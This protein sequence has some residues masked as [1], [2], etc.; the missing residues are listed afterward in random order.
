[1]KDLNTKKIIRELDAVLRGA[2]K[3]I[4]AMRRAGNFGVERKSR[5]SD[6]VT[7]GDKYAEKVIVA[8][9]TKHFPDHGMRGEEGTDTT[10]TSTTGSSYEWIID[11]IDGTTNY[12]KNNNL[13]GMSVGLYKNGKGV[14]GMIYYPALEKMT[15][16]IVG[17]GA[18]L[19]GKRIRFKKAGG[20]KT[21]EKLKD[22]LVSA[23]I[24]RGK[25]DLFKTLRDQSFNRRI[26]HGREPLA[27]GRAN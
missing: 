8:Y 25:E 18:Y 20:K 5:Y 7:R 22:A 24:S 2:G 10:S 19:N 11:P 4:L 26:F 3:K 21:N 9:I 27:F 16:A 14:L 17:G 23:S 13:F 1:M 15:W 6:I 12:S